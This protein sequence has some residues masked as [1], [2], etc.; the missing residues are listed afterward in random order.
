LKRQVI[1]GISHQQRQKPNI[2]NCS[3]PRTI[4]IGRYNFE[5][6]DNFTYLVSLV[7]GNGNVSEEITNCL[8]AA[9]RIIFG[10]KKSVSMYTTETWTKAKKDER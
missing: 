2:W 1:R 3:K 9:I 10:T 7:T 5:R 4:E 6:V 8:T